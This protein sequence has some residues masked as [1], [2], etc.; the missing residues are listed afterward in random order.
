MLGKNVVCI[1]YVYG[2]KLTSRILFI[3]YVKVAV[4]AVGIV[5]TVHAILSSS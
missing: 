2:F 3:V 4:D 5:N 1:G